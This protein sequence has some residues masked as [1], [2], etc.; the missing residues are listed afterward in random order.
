MKKTL[1]ILALI[2]ALVMLAGCGAGLEK[3]TDDEGDYYKIDTEVQIEDPEEKE[4]VDAFLA[5]LGEKSATKIMDYLDPDFGV[6]EEELTS[7]LTEASKWEN[8][9]KI[10]DTYSIKGVKSDVATRFKKD[11]ESGEY[12]MITPASDDMS[13]TL[14]LSENDNVSQ[15]ITLIT[16]KTA[17]GRK[18]M[19]IDTS[20]YAY[21]GKNGVEYYNLSKKAKEDGEEYL[22]YVYAQM[23]LN[24]CQPGNSLFYKE[25]NEMLEYANEMS[26]WGQEKY[27]MEIVDGNHKIHLIG[28]SLEED[29][30]IPMVFYQTNVDVKSSAFKNDALKVKNAF[31][32]K[33]PYMSK[34]FSKITIR[35]TN[36]DPATSS[37]QVEYESIVFD[38][39]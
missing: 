17:K 29:G 28:L 27:P 31:M 20:D 36:G 8:G 26:A 7:F 25:T 32:K 15:M 4:I 16:A 6:K 12:I 24:I 23:M 30:V 5:A 14:L 18:I 19:W 38:I 9:Y 2:L 1:R 13:V 33:Y 39:K 10:Y 22:A 34:G 35:G 37:E 21:Y 11:N 3:K